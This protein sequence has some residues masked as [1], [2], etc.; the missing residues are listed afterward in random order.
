T[1]SHAREL[2]SAFLFLPRPK[3]DAA[4]AVLAFCQMI[5]EAIIADE[6]PLRSAGALRAHP[7]IISSAMASAR[8]G[9]DDFEDRIQ[10]LRQRLDEIR[11]GRLELPPV[12]SRSPQQHA[13]HAIAFTIQR[14][15]I[16]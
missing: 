5:R 1:R 15:Q 16:P 2:Y 9:L 10:L 11:E 14:Y 7:A 4:C 13:L 3:R 12:E 8:K 6:S